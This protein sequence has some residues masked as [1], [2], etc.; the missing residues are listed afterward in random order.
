MAAIRILCLAFGTTTGSVWHV[1]FCMGLDY[2]H[3][4]LMKSA[5]LPK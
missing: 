2:K 4:V 3:T 5:C 1:K